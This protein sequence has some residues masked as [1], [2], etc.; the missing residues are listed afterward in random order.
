AKPKE[1]MA[2]IDT[3]ITIQGP[4]GIDGAAYETKAPLK[5]EN[6]PI[7][8]AITSIIPNRSVQ[9]RAAAAGV[10][11][12]AATK[13]T[14]TACMP[15]TTANTVKVVKTNSNALTGKPIVRAKF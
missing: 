10:I 3:I 4:V 11:S 7:N 15:T 14:P 8:A 2:I 9:K 13:T 6:A 12:M 1:A 5:P